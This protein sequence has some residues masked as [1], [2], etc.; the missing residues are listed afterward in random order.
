MSCLINTEKINPFQ[1]VGARHAGPSRAYA[2][3][4]Y[5]RIANTNN[6]IVDWLSFFKPA[7]ELT[8]LRLLTP[9]SCLLKKAFRQPRRLG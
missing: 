4:P 9:N 6:N 7:F 2:I 5:M 8:R 3:R 1:L